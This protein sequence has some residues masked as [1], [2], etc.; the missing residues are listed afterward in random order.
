MR[1][2]SAYSWVSVGFKSFSFDLEEGKLDVTMLE[3]FENI[4]LPVT[5][6]N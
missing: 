2:G 6:L 5:G 4:Y 3:M 1:A